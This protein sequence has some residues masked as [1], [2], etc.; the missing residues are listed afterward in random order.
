M[1]FSQIQSN[2]MFGTGEKNMIYS[3]NLWLKMLLGRK[4]NV[5][6]YEVV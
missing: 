1:H 5:Y 6:I 3:Y 2:S 4:G